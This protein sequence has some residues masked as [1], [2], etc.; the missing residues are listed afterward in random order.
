MFPRHPA[1][2]VLE[3]NLGQ[4][5]CPSSEQRIQIATEVTRIAGSGPCIVGLQEA[6]SQTISVVY[7]SLLES[8]GG[9]GVQ[10]VEY[11]RGNPIGGRFLHLAILCC[12]F[13]L[14]RKRYLK[15]ARRSDAGRKDS[16]RNSSYLSVLCH[17]LSGV[18]PPTLVS[19]AHITGYL[20]KPQPGELAADHAQ[21]RAGEKAVVR[22]E[23]KMWFEALEDTVRK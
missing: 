3:W 6:D 7:A 12:G 21:R 10:M 15:L 19:S 16:W 1:V 2:P 17:S 11:P 9:S 20:V 18:L 4:R 22:Q 13:R 23:V 5:E 14:E 8:H